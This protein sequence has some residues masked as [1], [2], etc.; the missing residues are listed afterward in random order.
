MSLNLNCFDSAN[1][2]TPLSLASPT[3]IS[4]LGPNERNT[5]MPMSKRTVVVRQIPNQLTP[6]KVNS[7]L[8]D[9]QVYGESQRPRFV[10][11]CS[12]VFNMD[13]ATMNLLLCCLEEVMKSNG[14][15]R[16]ASLR[17][18]AEAALQL[19][20]VKRLFEVYTTTD[21]AVN[22]FHQRAASIAML[23]FAT[24]AF[25]STVENAA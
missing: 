21:S 14:D 2:V 9:L 1:Q 17:P 12:T 13:S 25:D 19:A 4:C 23:P 6:S 15:V 5:P 24:E 10:L 22:S 3:P 8:S 20:G 11:D 16:L 18:E 7:F